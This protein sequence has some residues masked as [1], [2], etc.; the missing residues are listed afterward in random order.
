MELS[1]WGPDRL[2]LVV[3]QDQKRGVCVP[4]HSLNFFLNSVAH[5]SVMLGT[6]L[7]GYESG[8]CPISLLG[9]TVWTMRKFILRDVEHKIFPKSALL[10]GYLF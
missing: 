3:K 7:V 5:F 2:R 6:L 4:C 1:Y 10:K 8:H 9:M